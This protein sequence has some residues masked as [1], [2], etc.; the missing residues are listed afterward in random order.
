[1]VIGASA[2]IRIPIME[3]FDEPLLARNIKD[4]WAR[5]HISL[6]VY[7]REM[8]F[9]PLAKSL[10]GKLGAK[11]VNHAIA[12]ALLVTFVVTGVWHGV[13]VNFLFFGVLHGGATVLHHYYTLFL[14][15]RLS[16]EALKRY[17]S[18]MAIRAVATT[19]TFAFVS[20]T[21]LVFANDLPAVK[22]L[23]AVSPNTPEHLLF[24]PASE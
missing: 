13:G 15:K 1:M 7:V 2:L 12:L 3:N 6:S 16:R 19:L 8:L 14:R 17:G 9:S 20:S 10:G 22:R 24:E 21:F 5:W 23:V 11:N 4:F 18:S